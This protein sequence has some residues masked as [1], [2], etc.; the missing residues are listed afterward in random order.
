MS[1]QTFH[2]TVGCC[3]WPEFSGFWPLVLVGEGAVLD[4]SLKKQSWDFL[5][6]LEEITNG[7]LTQR[8]AS[9]WIQQVYPG[10]SVYQTSTVIPFSETNLNLTHNWSLKMTVYQERDVVHL[11]QLTMHSVQIYWSGPRGG[12]S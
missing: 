2:T 3:E 7:K 10:S 4:L 6:L 8:S 1:L 9:A 11:L 12:L 5:I